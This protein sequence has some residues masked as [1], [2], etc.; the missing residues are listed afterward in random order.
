MIKV[1]LCRPTCFDLITPC[2]GTVTVMSWASCNVLHSTFCYGQIPQLHF[3]PVY[4]TAFA[5]A[6]R[7][8]PGKV[9]PNPPTTHM[10]ELHTVWCKHNTLAGAVILF[11]ILLSGAD[12]FA[13][14]LA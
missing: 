10:C 4:V 1:V 12:I 3:M 6:L 2:V 11:C 8:T 13:R 14:Q 9:I 7:V 5:L